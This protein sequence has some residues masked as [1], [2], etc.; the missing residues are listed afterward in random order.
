MKLGCSSQSYDAALQGKK[1]DLFS[2]I[3]LCAEVLALDGIEIEDK[4]LPCT[5]PAFLRELRQRRA[6]RGLILSSL[7]IMN[8]FGL[9]TAPERAAQLDYLQ[10]GLEMARELG[11]PVLRIFAGWPARQNDEAL[12]AEMIE[13]LKQA[14]VHAEQAGVRLALENHNHGGFVRVGEDALRIFEQVGSDWLRL[15]LDT[16]NYIDGLPSIERT[17]SYAVHVHAK[18]HDIAADGSERTLDYPAIVAILRRAGY[19][20]FVSMEYEGAQDPFEVLPRAAAHLRKLLL[21]TEDRK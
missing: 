21:E 14:C 15:N 3:D 16:G 7:T 11:A 9:A 5:E 18:L 2:W 10:R 13:C 19:G 4:H 20:G 6:R 17:V 8:N 12:W 1:L